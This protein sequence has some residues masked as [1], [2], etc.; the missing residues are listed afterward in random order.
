[1]VVVGVDVDEILRSR[2]PWMRLSSAFC[3]VGSFSSGVGPVPVAAPWEPTAQGPVTGATGA[4]TGAMGAGTAVGM[5]AA[6][7]PPPPDAL[8]KMFRMRC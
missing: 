8:F 7:G 3:T 6:A 4:G 5:A 1:V 2:S